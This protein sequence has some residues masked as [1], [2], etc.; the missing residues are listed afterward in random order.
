LTNHPTFAES[1]MQARKRLRL[2]QWDLALRSGV[3]PQSIADYENGGAV[4]FRWGIPT[5]NLR[6]LE[7]VLGRLYH[8]APTMAVDPRRGKMV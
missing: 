1:L 6:K 8:E 2:S 5:D 4:P 7:K 3:S